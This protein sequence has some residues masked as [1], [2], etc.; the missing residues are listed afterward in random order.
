MTDIK[1]QIQS[2]IGDINQPDIYKR[3]PQ[4]APDLAAELGVSIYTW[5]DVRALKDYTQNHRYH[6]ANGE[7][8]D[9]ADNPISGPV[10]SN[11]VDMNGTTTGGANSTSPPRTDLRNNP[12]HHSS[13]LPPPSTGRANR[14]AK[15]KSA[16]SG[17]TYTS[18][19]RGVH[20]T[21]P[22]KRWEAQF[23]RNGKPTSLGCFDREDQAARAYDKMMLW[24][25]LHHASGIKGGITNFDPTEY[26]HELA[27]LQQISQDEL[28]AILRSDGRR[29]AAARTIQKAKREPST[30][31]PG[32]SGTTTI[33]TA[34]GGDGT[35]PGTKRSRSTSAAPMY[36]TGTG[37]AVEGAPST[38]TTDNDYDNN[39]GSG[40]AT[41][42]Q[43]Q[44]QQEGN[45]EATG[46]PPVMEAAE[47]GAPIAQPS[48]P[49]QEEEPKPMVVE[50]GQQD[51][52]QVQQ[53]QQQQPQGDTST[54]RMEEGGV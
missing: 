14:A 16:S 46:K 13:G 24:C 47:G 2:L 51:Q 26:E 12:R 42:L 25:E 8:P 18:K 15:G 34:D 5:D 52:V 36:T 38:T 41:L 9:T 6:Q 3:R 39:D 35:V 54:A 49:A 33:D 17:R 30:G 23:R 43:Q 11:P 40:S 29:Q 45:N 22:T 21:F 44:Q 32:T 10:L 28:V 48:A 37:T 31:P 19:F 7:A 50:D 1:S 20:Q 4:G 27:L 53:Q